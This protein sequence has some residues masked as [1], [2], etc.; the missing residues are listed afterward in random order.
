MWPLLLLQTDGTLPEATQQVARQ[1]RAR[2]FEV[3]FAKWT[4][5]TPYLIATV[6]DPETGLTARWTPGSGSQSVPLVIQLDHGRSIDRDTI[7]RRLDPALRSD[8]ALAT[9]HLNGR[10]SVRA[11]LTSDPDRSAWDRAAALV[12]GLRRLVRLSD[13]S[14]DP[15][16]RRR[17][18][19]R[20]RV[21][22]MTMED[23]EDLAYTRNWFR[24]RPGWMGGVSGQSPLESYPTP[25]VMVY[26]PSWGMK[27]DRFSEERATLSLVPDLHFH[28]VA[29]ESRKRAIETA[30]PGWTFYW[31]RE[32]DDLQWGGPRWNL[33]LTGGYTLAEI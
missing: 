31:D 30:M 29:T 24:I 19:L 26:L 22:S 14:R 6:R 32:E 27:P 12:R 13:A 28:H 23:A 17:L 21:T 25:G 20:T 2:G 8:L 3:K 5:E 1:L 9:L 18:D 10:V 16:T 15:W 11:G 4:G 33:N 7:R